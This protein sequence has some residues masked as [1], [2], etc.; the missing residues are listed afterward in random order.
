MSKQ[1]LGYVIYRGPSRIDGKPIVA[2]MTGLHG[3][4]NRKT[5]NILQTYILREDVNPLTARAEGG[6]VSICGDCIHRLRKSCYVNLGRGPLTV[7]AAYLRGR[8]EANLV[9]ASRAAAGRTVRLG[10]YGD[11]YAVPAWVWRELL[12]AAASWRGYTHQ[13]QQPDA[14]P[15]MAWCMASVDTPAEQATAK[16]TG[17]RTFRVRHVDEPTLPG[18]FPCPAS[19]EAGHRVQ[20]ATC[21]ACSGTSRGVAQASPVIIVHGVN[22]RKF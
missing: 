1:P 20:C 12:H 6:D 7:H 22:A 17:Y 14:A 11:P 21:T 3:S 13:W 18:E 19:D 2:I 10:T 8:Y 5:G 9:A 16:A 4:T 15:Y